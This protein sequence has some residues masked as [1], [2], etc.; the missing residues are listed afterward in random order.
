ME[1]VLKRI[2]GTLNGEITISGFRS[3]GLHRGVRLLGLQLVAP[4]G[5]TVLA[6]DSAEAE[7]SIREVLSGEIALSGVTLWRPRLTVTK[8]APDRPFNLTAFLIGSESP[9]LELSGEGE[10]AEA[11]V[12]FLLDEVEIRDGTVEVRYPLTA[13]PNPSSRLITEPGPDGQGVLRVFGFYG[14]DGHF[15]GVV[16]ADPAVEGIR[17]NVTRLTLEAEV[18]EEPVRVQDFDGRVSWSGN[19]ILAEAETVRLLGGTASGSAVVELVEGSVPDFTVD[20]VL[21]GIDLPELRW[22]EPRLPDARVSGRLAMGLRSQGLRASWSGAML[23]IGGGEIEADGAL[24][25]PSGGEL[26]LENVTLDVSSVPVS[27]LGKL[28][29]V[30]PPLEGRLS[31]NLDISGTMD[32]MAVSGRMDLLEPSVSPTSGEIEGVLHLRRPRGVT[33]M[34]ARLTALDLGLVNRMREGLMLDGSVNLDI[35]ADGRL[36]TGVRV[37]VMATLPEPGAEASYVSLEGSLTEV[38]G[39]VQIELDGELDPFSIAGVVSDESPLSRLGFIRGTVHAEGSLADLI[40]RSDLT[41]EGGRLTLESRFDARSPFASYRLRVEADDF[42]PL[43]VAPW[44]PGGTVLSGS[45]DLLG[46]GGDL[47]TAELVGTMRLRESRFADLTVDTV[48]I[49]LRI[50]NGIVTMDEVQGRIGGVTVE[51]AGQLAVTGS[52]GPE[53]VRVSFETGGL[54]G[55]RPLLRS[56]DV[57]AGDTL[58]VLERQI[59]EFEGIDPDTLPTLAEVLVAGRMAGEFT[60]NGSFENLSVTG[61]AAV[62][63]ALYAGNRVGRAEVSF[64]ATGLFTPEREVSAQ[65]DAGAIRVLQR[66][67]DSVSVNVRYRE[68][69]GNVNVFLVRSPEES[70][71][72]LLA[73]EEEGDVRT[74]HLDELVF[75]FPEERWNLG[76]PATISWDPDGLTFRDFRM[77]RPGVGGMRL[78]AQGR[79]PF[80]GEADFGLEAEA[81]DIRWIAHL[82]QLDDVLEGVVDLEFNVTGTDDEPVM[83]LAI[84]TDGF[85]FR[86]YVLERVEADVEY[87]ARRV[88]GDVALGNDSL[89]VLTL[90]GEIPLD[91]SFNAVEERFPEEVIDLVVVSDRLPLSLF[92]APFPGYQ[93]VVGTMSGCVEVGGTSRSLAPRGQI[94]VDG[95]GAFLGGLGVR[96]EEV[97]GTLDWFPDGRLEVDMSARALGTAAVE[98][99][100]SLTTALDPGFDLAIRFDDFQAMD[101]RD[102]T[103]RVS[104]DLRVEGSFSRPVISGDLFL[105]GGTLFYEEFQRAAEVADLFFER[106]AAMTDLLGANATAFGSR[107][108]IAGE[109]LFLQNIR[110]E[111]TTLTARRDNWIRS[112]LMNVELEGD[113]DLLYDRQTQDLALV[114][115]LQ[116]VRGSLAFGPRGLRKQFQVDGG[117][118]RFLGTPGINPDLD[119]TASEPIRTPEG[120]RLTIIAEITGTLLSPRVALRSD[121]AGISE[122]D[123]L[124]Y[125]WFGRP[126]YALTSGQSEAVGAGMAVGLSTISSELGAV[127]TQGLGLD[128]LDYLSI[129]QQDLGALGSLRSN[130]VQGA[131]G[132]TVVETGF[133]VA[134]DMFLTLLF[135][136]ASAAGG[137]VQSWPGIRFEWVA[138]RGYTMQSYFEDQFF[139][140]RALGFGEFGVQSKKGLGLSIFRDWAY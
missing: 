37:V 101:R 24:S 26:A 113:L 89:Q 63:D 10:P 130:N 25:Q 72:G 136:P 106:T 79:I 99:T 88:T 98:G 70:Y 33:G 31:G 56:G 129:T 110:M 17:M 15:D 49:E 140:G 83:D 62:D 51:G 44:L 91:L 107:P 133:Y 81:L 118:M 82:L 105:D 43:E 61:R 47:R 23:A 134:D 109:N 2:E 1:Q 103:G 69:S 139:R 53:D 137:G 19:R 93:E 55:L 116:A 35:R 108:F 120:D 94:I 104:G 132:T 76:G 75:R 64:S 6:V 117:T 34:T 119:L 28:I 57:I 97:G 42:D 16:L 48:S 123:L 36:E 60:V 27:V 5:S 122:D 96:V 73:F 86:D 29:S 125:L 58:T 87:A 90:D 30:A 135:R 126:T 100:V 22:L 11:A 52:G 13:P 8:E 124:S 80:D 38:D 66:D 92:M 14:I 39:E 46:E 54:E 71:S 77:R 112:E 74:L 111:N 85:R 84:S 138:S 32:S 67:F 41:T 78:Q 45:F 128:F 21:D 20:A 68:P 114:G 12:R 9:V 95:G 59:L 40:L 4:D 115:A 131:L 121:E 65:I 18:F 127:M 3:P 102:A 7:Y 50:S